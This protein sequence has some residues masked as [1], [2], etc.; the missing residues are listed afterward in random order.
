MSVP[1]LGRL[2]I[3]IE[4]DRAAPELTTQY[5]YCLVRRIV[6]MIPATDRM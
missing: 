1:P 5:R 2:P 6:R 3:V 4:D